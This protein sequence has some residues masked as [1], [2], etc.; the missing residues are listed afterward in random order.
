MFQSTPRL[1]DTLLNQIMKGSRM[2]IEELKSLDSTQWEFFAEDVLWYIGYEIIGRPS[3]GNDQGKDLIVRKSGITYLVSCKHYANSGKAIGPDIEKN[4]SDRVLRHECDGFIAFYSTHATS[5]LESQF[6]QLSN[7]KKMPIECI[8]FYQ[9]D[10]LDIIPNMTG[11]TLQKY[12]PEPHKLHHHVNKTDW[13][14]FPLKCQNP[15]CNRDVISKENIVW[16]RV[17]LLRINGVLELMYGCKFCL[18]DFGDSAI[19]YNGDIDTLKYF[20]GNIEIYWW[21]F[22]QI[23]YIEEL[24][25]LNNLINI[26]SVHPDF[27]GTSAHL[28]K[29]WSEVQSAMLQIQVPIH[30][31]KWI[32]P[33]RVFSV[34]EITGNH[35]TDLMLHAK[36]NKQFLNELIEKSTNR[37]T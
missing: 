34:P 16:S 6:E 5:N 3:E 22:S 2:Y 19:V 31:G 32:D 37:K 1:V 26:C 8:K 27:S 4:I 17:Q 13:D 18:P 21:E 24:I 36:N 9:S 29:S 25:S 30:W 12:F 14:Y 28:Y 35:F 15:K 33:K 20:D 23:R 10:I 7:R 11:Y